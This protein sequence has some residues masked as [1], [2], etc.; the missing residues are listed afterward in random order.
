MR[1]KLAIVKPT[2]RD[3]VKEPRVSR[4][5]PAARPIFSL[6]LTSPDNSRGVQELTT[7]AD[8]VL[9]KRLENVRG[10]GAV[11]LVGGVKREVNVYLRPQAME[12]FGEIGRAHV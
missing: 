4:F 2:F 12:G 11:S 1:E 7:Y 5:D 8:Q 6:A 9:R 3:E 10:V